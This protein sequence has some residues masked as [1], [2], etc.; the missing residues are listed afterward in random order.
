M[1]LLSGAGVSTWQLIKSNMGKE[2]ATKPLGELLN[3]PFETPKRSLFGE[4]CPSEWNKFQKA[5][6]E[7]APSCSVA[8][9]SVC[10]RAPSSATNFVGAQVEVE[11]LLLE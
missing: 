2:A 11:L 9:T 5:L 1:I 10:A 8:E 7:N 6:A 3:V 4:P